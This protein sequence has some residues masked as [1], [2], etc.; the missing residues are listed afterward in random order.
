MRLEI[1]SAAT[2]HRQSLEA[3]ILSLQS[4]RLSRSSIFTRI[5]SISSPM[6]PVVETEARTELK[7]IDL[8]LS[9][10]GI[11]GPGGAALMQ[12][13]HADHRTPVSL[14]GS[15]DPSNLVALCPKHNAAK[16]AHS[17]YM[18]VLRCL[19]NPDL[20]TCGGYAPNARII[21]SVLLEAYPRT[22][23]A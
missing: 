12:G 22:W 15:D 1:Y 23:I 14:G 19:Q 3:A 17:E 10:D 11:C 5:T 13:F 4:G 6:D 18:F 7:R 20:A 9:S 21:E 8:F 2:K 16:A